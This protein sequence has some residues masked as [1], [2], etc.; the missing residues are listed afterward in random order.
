RTRKAARPA[1]SRCDCGGKSAQSARPC[2]RRIRV[3]GA[4]SFVRL[5]ERAT[6]VRHS[7]TTVPARKAVMPP[8]SCGGLTVFTSAATMLSPASPWRSCSP[9][10]AVA[11]PHAGVQTPGAQDGSKIHVE[12]KIDRPVGEPLVDV[13]ERRGDLALVEIDFVDQ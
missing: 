13:D 12:A 5:S 8:T 3:G 11:P 4:G 2:Q 9:S 1:H 10:R 6:R 7:S